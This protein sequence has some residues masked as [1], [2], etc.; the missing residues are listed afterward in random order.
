MSDKHGMVW[1]TELMTRDVP[2]AVAY[3]KATCGWQF[4]TMPMQD[5]AGDYYIGKVGETP[6]IGIMD[7]THMTH[8][9]GVPAHWFSYFA[10][11]DVDAAVSATAE[12]G[13]QVMR[14]PFEVPG[15]GRIA[16]L[17]DPTGAAMGL[18]TPAVPATS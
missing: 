11:D 12:Q 2:G 9:D 6:M 13:G 1:W 5:A 4:D 3:Y 17:Q 10:V 15:I 18:I 8:L 7:M 16:I 14:E